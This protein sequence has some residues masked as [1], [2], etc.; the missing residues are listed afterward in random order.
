LPLLKFQPSYIHTRR[1]EPVT[2]NGPLYTSRRH[3]SDYGVN[4]RK[5]FWK[6]LSVFKN[7]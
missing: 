1:R 3:T 4:K 6:S 7:Y 5:V 2:E